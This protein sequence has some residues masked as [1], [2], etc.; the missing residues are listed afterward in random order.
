MRKNLLFTVALA[1]LLFLA[2]TT[3]F[4]PAPDDRGTASAR[5][6]ATSARSQ[7]G[8]DPA[9]RSDVP[10]SSTN[11]ESAISDA[12]RQVRGLSGEESL[13]PENDG[14]LFFANHPGQHFTSWFQQDGVII[15]SQ[16][17]AR[18][19]K[20]SPR[21]HQ[22]AR[23]VA[24]GTRV[25]YEYGDGTVEWFDNAEGGLEHGMVLAQR[26]AASSD[27]VRIAFG[28]GGLEAKTE[29]QGSG[30][31]VFSDATGTPVYGYRDLKAWDA[32]GRV[33]DTSLAA[34]EGGIEW[35]VNDTAAAYPITIDPLIVN[36]KALPIPPGRSQFGSNVDIDGDTA[37][38][39][40]YTETT[41]LGANVGGVYVFRYSAGAWALEARLASFDPA[42]G[43]FFGRGLAFDGDLAAV[44]VGMDDNPVPGGTIQLFRRSGTVWSFFSR[45]LPP[46]PAY[47]FGNNL[48]L[49][50]E[51]LLVGRPGEVGL[52]GLPGE[53]RVLVYEVTA[54]GWNG[55]QVLFAQGGG[56]AQDQFGTSVAIDGN[57]IAVGAPYCDVNGRT[58]TGAV[59]VFAGGGSFWSQQAK[60]T[61]PD[62]LASEQLGLSVAIDSGR[63]VAGAPY[64]SRAGKQDGVAYVFSSAGGWALEGSFAAPSETNINIGFGSAVAIAGNH[65]AIST[66][67][68]KAYGGQVLLYQRVGKTWLRRAPLGSSTPGDTR[69]PV[70]AMDDSFLIAGYPILEGGGNATTYALGNSS[71]AQ[72][73]AVFTGADT[74]LV[75]TTH[76]TPVNYGEVATGPSAAW[77]ITI[78]NDGTATLQV[79]SATFLPGSNPDLSVDPISIFPGDLSIAPG[80]TAKVIV[81]T[82]FN[83]AGVKSGT[84]RLASNDV[85]EANF[86]IPL[87]FTA[88][89]PPAPLGLRITKEFGSIVLRYPHTQFSLYRV[90]ISPDLQNWSYIGNMQ[91][92]SDPVTFEQI[93]VF[94][95]FNPPP[96]KAFYRVVVE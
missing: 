47:Y 78:F 8:A 43:E 52:N 31:L 89:I 6:P 11:L 55:P 76:G 26:P 40:D 83:D 77:P 91:T 79:S 14:T 15:R 20:I 12:R 21:D 24:E 27:K 54:G 38:V 68:F 28:I 87:S 84:L 39:G 90:D 42:A 46:S 74:S 17:G 64:Q 82:Q 65:M 33:L 23:V 72:E 9:V 66:T 93:R 57:Q 75:E 53:G 67:Y 95:D 7:R 45:I 61:V 25:R 4:S 94:R 70:L 1:A 58:D 37:L 35:V 60:L 2:G 44:G 22:S 50:G 36:L 59:Y 16:E 56:A 80:E 85:D 63:V 62:A 96:G 73:I 41:A 51:T 19:V 48:A 10:A 88:V 5:H 29:G 81:R 49:E 34:V 30:N 92:E 32:N 3:R 71:P 13:L 18:E 86:D 69:F